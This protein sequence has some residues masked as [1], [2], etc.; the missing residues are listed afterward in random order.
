MENS[1]LPRIPLGRDLPAIPSVE[2]DKDPEY[3]HLDTMKRALQ[4]LVVW[5]LLGACQ[6]SKKTEWAIPPEVGQGL[7]KTDSL[8]ALLRWLEGRDEYPAETLRI[9]TLYKLVEK[10]SSDAPDSAHQIFTQLQATAQKTSYALADGL[11]LLALV[12]LWG[13]ENRYDSAWV[14][15]QLAAQRFEAIGRIE[16]A[17]TSYHLA[18]INYH[19][20]GETKR[21]IEFY[22]KAMNI[23]EYLKD[24][25]KLTASYNNMGAAYRDMGNYWEAI[26]YLEKAAEWCA[27][28]QD[29]VKLAGAY[30][31]LGVL[32]RDQGRYPEALSY[33]QK[34]CQIRETIGDIRGLASSYTNLGSLY[35]MLDQSERGLEYL[36][37]AARIRESINDK[38]GLA[39]TYTNLGS[40]HQKMKF[41]PE[42]MAYYQ[43]AAHIRLSLGDKGRV[44]DT[45][46]SIGSLY[47]SQNN[48]DSALVY[49]MKAYR[50]AVNS[51]DKSELADIYANLGSV[52]QKKGLYDK[53]LIYQD[54]AL[55]LANQLHANDLLMIVHRDLAHTHASLARNGVISHWPKA[56]KHHELFTAYKDSI[57]NEDNIRQLERLQN[58]YDY[59][60]KEALMKAQQEQERAVAAAEVRRREVQ[61]NLSLLVLSIALI[62]MGIFGVLYRK[63]RRQKKLLQA[64]SEEINRK[65]A[66]LELYNAELEVTNK[67]LEASNEVIRR[68]A[69]A[70]LEKNEE[71]LDSIR[72]AQRIQQAILPPDEKYRRLLPDSFLVYLPRDIVAG[73]FYWIEEKEKY[74]YVGIADATGHGVPGAFVSIVCASALNKA[75]IEENL[76]NPSQIL[77]RVKTLV[78]Q[79]LT[80]DGGKIRDGMDMGLIRINKDNRREIVF[81]GAN[82]PLWII[83]TDGQLIEIDGTKQAVGYSEV[84][85]EF[86]EVFIDLHG[87]VPAML[88]MF[89]DGLVDQM[90]GPKGRKL[91]AK[92]LR[93][94]LLGLYLKPV[95]AQAIALER[96]FMEW[97]QNIHQIDDVTCFG[98]RIT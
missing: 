14:Y 34:A 32:Y 80:Q 29:L 26:R 88:Y 18:G 52:Y 5:M 60:K 11:V 67:A 93:E 28:A 64:Q 65:N 43:K 42:A 49:Y 94:V 35:D 9:L 20:A 92:G 25:L 22:Q 16:W 68:Q 72:Y 56:Y 87:Q 97:R 36:M 12:H 40:L 19:Q 8:M 90:G 45:Y 13:N 3:V 81:S 21:A 57:L 39:Y 46:N 75:V 77:S 79:Q 17:A 48:Y 91:M 71:I 54:S 61:R 31:N 15:A 98:L 38:R 66:D 96:F 51:D 47:E 86:K 85:K 83:N 78:T 41:Y 10:I 84:D 23:F 82:R 37:R 70:L 24:T 30:N 59:E 76:E 95:E 53:A 69:D 33:F 4:A 89:T 62:G 55:L 63:I 6:V 44:A 7:S 74:L 73:D 58:Q 1:L 50:Y 27:V 2:R